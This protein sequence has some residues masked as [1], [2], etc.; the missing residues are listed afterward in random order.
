MQPAVAGQ[1]VSLLLEL[2]Q[3]VQIRRLP[4]APRHY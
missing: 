2:M 4:V 3:P 1:R